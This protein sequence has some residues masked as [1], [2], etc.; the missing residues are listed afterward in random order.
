MNSLYAAVI[1]LVIVLIVVGG[2]SLRDYLF[3]V[4][5]PR[6]P[7]NGITGVLRD[8]TT[9]FYAK[10]GP[11]GRALYCVKD[12]DRPAWC[13]RLPLPAII[14]AN[15]AS[16]PSRC[17]D[18]VWGFS[19]NPG[20]LCGLKESGPNLVSGATADKIARDRCGHTARLVC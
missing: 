2:I 12:G 15:E 5:S 16:D 10:L 9:S 4:P 8:C 6:E 14:E 20:L 11:D 1:V 13:K 18:V 7:S 17:S 19:C 3:R